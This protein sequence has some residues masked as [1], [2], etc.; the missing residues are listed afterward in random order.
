[1]IPDPSR[2]SWIPVGR[3]DNSAMHE[4]IRLEEI[5]AAQRRIQ[6]RALRTPLVRL[7][8]D[9]APADIHLKLE[10]LQPIGSFKLRG[11]LNLLDQMNPDELASGVWTASAG[12]MAQG[13]AWS[14]REKG[15][16][17]TVVVPDTAPEA[18]L[19]AIRRLGAAIVTVT[20]E[21]F[22]EILATRHH[23]GMSGT[24][25]HAFSDRRMMAGN[26][27]IGLEILEDLPDVDVI[28]VPY[29]GGGLS[30]GIASAV[31][32]STKQVKVFACEPETAAPLN[33]SL[34]AGKPVTPPFEWTFIDGAGGPR[35]YPEMFDL[36]QQVLDGA[37]M[38]PVDAVKQAIALLMERNHVVAEG[39]GALGVSAALGGLA[40]AGRV[41]C[42]VS[43]GNIDQ[44]VLASIL[45]KESA[46]RGAVAP[47]RA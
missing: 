2:P 16:H 20:R 46:M 15:I 12:N 37:F 13:L 30:C 6:G 10:N 41:C 27:T 19:S 8:V 42:V 32:A 21:A 14:A 25:A 34:A 1:M 33:H 31:K 9:D 47:P 7:N 5:L 29:G 43:G 26:G 40:G 3:P 22:F 38:V 36:A 35:V 39:A 44:A 23:P 45:Q 17:C 28:V 4:P 11:A 24:F 18:K